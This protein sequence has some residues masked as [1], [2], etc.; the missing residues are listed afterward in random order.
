MISTKESQ[1]NFSRN[2]QA[3]TK[4]T[5]LSATTPAASTTQVSDRSSAAL[6]L[7]LVL[8]FTESRGFKKAF[9]RTISGAVDLITFP[10]PDYEKSPVKPDPLTEPST[11]KA[12]AP[13]T[14]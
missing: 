11:A 4:A 1:P 9:P 13:A 5:A 12:K 2:T 10:I 6:A 8:I 3:N 7:F 14:K